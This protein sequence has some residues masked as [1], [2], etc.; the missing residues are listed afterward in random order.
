M[1]TFEKNRIKDII[2][3]MAEE[4]GISPEEV[5]ASMQQCIDA[6]WKNRNGAAKNEREKFFSGDQKPTVEE[7][8][9]RLR[10]EVRAQF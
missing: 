6:A 7:F 4:E 5:H 10:K 9:L 2:N 3:Q 1:T 8:L